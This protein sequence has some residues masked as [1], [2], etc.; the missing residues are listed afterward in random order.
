MAQLLVVDDKQVHLDWI[1]RLLKDRGRPLGYEV[2][3]ATTDWKE[4]RQV[5]EENPEQVDIV[6][7]DLEDTET[8]DFVGFSVIKQAREANKGVIAI[9]S[10]LNDEQHMRDVLD[11]GAD[12]YVKKPFKP[13][14]RTWD[15]YPKELRRSAELSMYFALRRFAEEPGAQMP[16]FDVFL[17]Y[18][19]Q[20]EKLAKEI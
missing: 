9:S 12:F 18:S 7:T 19:H 15:Q 2:A 1:V 16:R 6:V 20:D 11:S 3:V 4:A 13:D 14:K 17:S 10:F 5:L 8:G